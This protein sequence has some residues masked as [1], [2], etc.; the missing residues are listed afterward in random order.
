MTEAIWLTLGLAIGGAAGWF[1]TRAK[2]AKVSANP[3]PKHPPGM[4]EKEPYS[5]RP[6]VLTS[7]ER[8]FYEVLRAVLPDDYTVLLKV[9]L[10][11]LVNVTYGAGDRQSA[12]AQVCSKSLDFVVCN[13][14]L[15]PVVTIDLIDGTLGRSTTQTREL[16]DRV[17]EK[18]ALPIERVPLR[19]SYDEAS[20]RQIMAKHVKLHSVSNAAP[21]LAISA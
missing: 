19:P 8:S 21:Q 13:A 2:A 11:D 15:T 16:M 7:G 18:V 14:A 12:H 9:R 3:I 5:L 6:S 20:L 4:E 17:L 1:I 10:G